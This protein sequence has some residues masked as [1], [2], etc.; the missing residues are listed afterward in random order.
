[1]DILREKK[2]G[3]LKANDQVKKEVSAHYRQEIKKLQEDP[4]YKPISYN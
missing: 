4:D 3:I 2:N 1:M